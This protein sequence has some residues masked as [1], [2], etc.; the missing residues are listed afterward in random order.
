[1]I[2]M[3][4]PGRSPS[5]ISYCGGPRLRDDDAVRGG[6]RAQTCICAKSG[7]RPKR[8]EQRI[9]GSVAGVAAPFAR[10]RQSGDWRSR[11]RIPGTDDSWQLR[12]SAE[13]LNRTRG[14]SS[15]DLSQFL[16]GQVARALRVH[17]YIAKKSPAAG[18]QQDNTQSCDDALAQYSGSILVPRLP[19]RERRGAHRR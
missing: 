12:L 4:Q 19:Q 11:N 13:T 2:R 16:A 15:R 5:R 6:S 17:M 10:R 7:P 18:K 9:A 14:V 8:Q 1:M 3:K